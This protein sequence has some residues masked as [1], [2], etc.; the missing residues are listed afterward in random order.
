MPRRKF[1]ERNSEEI[2]AARAIGQLI[3][4]VRG[5]DKLLH[6]Q[7][8]PAPGSRLWDDDQRVPHYPIS[9]FATQQFAT[10]IGCIEALASWVGYEVRDDYVEI[11][12]QPFGG[13]ALLRSA[14]ESG[15]WAIWV[16]YPEN[17]KLRIRRRL[18]QQVEEWRSAAKFAE[19]AGRRGLDIEL[20]LDRIQRFGDEAG[21]P[22]WDARMGRKADAA[23]VKNGKPTNRAP[24]MTHL[25]QSVERHRQI[26]H[27]LSFYATWQLASASAHGK[28]WANP[29]VQDLVTEEG[30]QTEYGAT[31]RATTKYGMLLLVLD[32]CVEALQLALSRFFELGSHN[33]Q[34]PTPVSAPSLMQ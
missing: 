20:K 19:S 13:Y 21:V 29:L 10:L 18:A 23:R 26:P 1:P 17:Y 14:L 4:S 28:F 34:K 2:K 30:T 15:A 24:S 8:E 25:L 3:D 12:T 31:V 32:K 5:H 6:Q 22:E 16:L 33:G 9:D 27:G 11:A 7:W